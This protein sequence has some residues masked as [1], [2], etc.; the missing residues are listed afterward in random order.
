MAPR[1]VLVKVQVTVSPAATLNVA[2]AFWTL[3][4]LLASSQVTLVRSQP[5]LAASVETYCPGATSTEIVPLF[6]LIEPA[7][8]PV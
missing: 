5:A 1:L 7:G 2:L 6:S 8:V 3:P 4:T